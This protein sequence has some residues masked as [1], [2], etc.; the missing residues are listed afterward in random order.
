MIKFETQK[1][2]YSTMFGGKGTTTYEI[3]CDPKD[4]KEELLEQLQQKFDFHE[5]YPG[6]SYIEYWYKQD[7][8]VV[9]T[10]RSWGCD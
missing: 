10:C 5:A 4:T 9:V 2:T 8:K 6:C 7:N 3:E 1:Q